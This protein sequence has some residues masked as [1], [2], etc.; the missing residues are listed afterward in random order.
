MFH[1]D[2]HSVTPRVRAAHSGST[3]ATAT[4]SSSWLSAL[5]TAGADKRI[6][7]IQTIKDDGTSADEVLGVAR[8]F[9]LPISLVFSS[10][11]CFLFYKKYFGEAFPPVA[12]IGGAIVIALLIEA[13]KVWFGIRAL[14]YVYFGKPLSSI[15][16]TVLFLAVL[17]FASVAFYWS[18]TNSTSGLHDMAAANAWAANQSEFTVNTTDIDRQIAEAR[19]AQK[20]AGKIKWKGTVTVDA[21]RAIRKQEDNI[22]RLQEQ[23]AKLIDQAAAD[24][25]DKKKYQGEQ[26]QKA[27]SWT[28]LVGGIVEGIQLLL[29]LIAASCEKLLSDRNPVGAKQAGPNHSPLPNSGVNLNG[30]TYAGFKT[31]PDGNYIPVNDPPAA[32]HDPNAFTVTQP[33]PPVSQFD[34]AEPDWT[35][36]MPDEVLRWFESELRKEPSHLERKD[37][38]KATVIARIHNKLRRAHTTIDRMNRGAFSPDAAKR[39][40]LYLSNTIEP[41]LNAQA[42]P[43]EGFDDLLASLRHKTEGEAVIL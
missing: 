14:R 10:V 30:H 15:A 33:P 5:W 26:T 1:L 6:R 12:A 23:R 43:Y 34:A 25:A 42:R 21:Q 22:A 36:F 11:F 20:E 41:L 8:D 2:F 19:Q 32:R 7:Q 17:G 27:A 39:F 13:G 4:R 24:H 31:G 35:A 38:N 37:A 40:G 9:L 28:R 3:G 16:N 18:F 29:L